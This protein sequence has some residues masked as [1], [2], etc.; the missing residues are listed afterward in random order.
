MS[1]QVDVTVLPQ[2]LVEVNVDED[3]S[4]V[5]VTVVTSNVEVVYSPVIVSV[6]VE[7]GG[8]GG[9]PSGPDTDYAPSV[10]L[11]AVK[12]PSTAFG[13]HGKC[14]HQTATLASPPIHTY[15]Y[16]GEKWQVVVYGVV[17]PTS[18]AKQAYITKRNVTKKTA[19]ETPVHL[20][21]FDTHPQQ[22]WSEDNHNAIPVA[23]DR[24]GFFHVI[25]N[26]HYDNVL[27][28]RSQ[29]ANSITGGF[30]SVSPLV[31]SEREIGIVGAGGGTYPYFF[32]LNNAAKTLYLHMRWNGSY[33][34]TFDGF[35]HGP[36]HTGASKSWLYVYNPDLQTW[37]N[38]FPGDTA[39]FDGYTPNPALPAGN[40]QRG[41]YILGGAIDSENRIG[42][43][44]TWRWQED[45]EAFLGTNLQH[46]QVE[47]I[48]LE[49][50]QLGVT[51]TIKKMDGTTLTA[52]IVEKE[53]DRALITLE[54][55]GSN[56]ATM[57]AQGIGNH[58]SPCFDDQDKPHILVKRGDG[59]G[60]TY[61]N[62]VYWDGNSWETNVITD[63]WWVSAIG[64]TSSLVAA[65]GDEVWALVN[66]AH[67]GKGMWAVDMT[68]GSPTYSRKK[69]LLFDMPLYGCTPYPDYNAKAEV[70]K[71]TMQLT[72]IG[73]GSISNPWLYQ[74]QLLNVLDVRLDKIPAMAR[75][76]IK[77]PRLQVINRYE[78]PNIGY[79]GL[80][81]NQTAAANTDQLGYL[82]NISL[83][84][85]GMNR[86][87]FTRLGAFGRI[88]TADRI[89]IIELGELV[90]LSWVPRTKLYFTSTVNALLETPWVPL[91]PIT[92]AVLSRQLQVR[93]YTRTLEKQSFSLGGATNGVFTITLGGYTTVN[94]AYNATA[95]DVETALWKL[96]NLTRGEFT[97][98]GGPLPGTA[99]TITFFGPTAGTDLAA[100]T[101]ND[102]SLVGETITVSEVLKGG[103]AGGDGFIGQGVG[104][105]GLYAELAVIE[106][107]DT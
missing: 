25:G 26:M 4:T 77:P 24:D 35:A 86:Q 97:V 50:L 37:A 44:Y 66:G 65:P 51:P 18:G 29:V 72:Q 30:T 78:L 100:L 31:N 36:F 48:R 6:S 82:Q 85:V 2:Q 19:W 58:G 43:W 68:I 106:G 55:D 56:D 60:N 94:I 63:A 8:G 61:T 59:G 70:E 89:M 21:H 7:G 76:E 81:I 107:E 83:N 3:G 20:S 69:F 49:N 84:R 93:A 32:R 10:E 34:T 92:D 5:P 99:V 91:P 22:G 102:V 101:I 71:L 57:L 87:M 23:V 14:T 41:I 16:A 39:L 28:V 9:G 96:P 88:G 104:L 47:F 13:I 67:E 12:L 62:H 80:V 40:D 42:L 103:Q 98:T 90:G 74:A 17:N 54:S 53:G 64:I 46:E 95:A 52:P 105:R 15:T 11:G 79:D 45:D 1:A 73:L 33:G 38:A 27:Y 75:R